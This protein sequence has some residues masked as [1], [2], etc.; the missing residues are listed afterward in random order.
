MIKIFIW[1]RFTFFLRLCYHRL[2]RLA[3]V[4]KVDRED[5]KFIGDR[6]MQTGD[7]R[8]LLVLARRLES[9]YSFNSN[10]ITL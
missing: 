7:Q 6:R 1:K 8:Y 3:R 9:R 2:R 4:D 5:A 10:T